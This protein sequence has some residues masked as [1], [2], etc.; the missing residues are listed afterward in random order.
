MISATEGTKAKLNNHVELAR[1][2][3]LHLDCVTA[4]GRNPISLS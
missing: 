2:R 4:W 1:T 3:G